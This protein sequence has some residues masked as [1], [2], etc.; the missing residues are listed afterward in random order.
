MYL[1]KPLL[2]LF[3]QN[4][5]NNATEQSFEKQNMLFSILAPLL[6]AMRL[7]PDREPPQIGA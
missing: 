7:A 2:L 3:H 1:F 6:H 5:S 4:G